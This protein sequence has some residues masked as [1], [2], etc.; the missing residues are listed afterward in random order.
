[1]KALADRQRFVQAAGG[2]FEAR[3]GERDERRLEQRPLQVPEVAVAALYLLQRSCQLLE[4]VKIA[5]LQC[6]QLLGID[7]QS[8]HRVLADRR[9]QRKCALGGIS[10]PR[11]VELI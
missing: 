5:E 11:E 10:G 2:E 6:D 9:G 1:A 8:L 7:R 4:P 3:P